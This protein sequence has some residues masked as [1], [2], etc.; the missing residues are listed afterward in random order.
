MSLPRAAIWTLLLLWALFMGLSLLALT[1]EPTGEGFLRGLNRVTGF[2]GWQ[3]GAA[4]VAFL[5][6]LGV[7]PLDRG[8]MLRR[9][10]RLP[11]WWAVM[12]LGLLL[13]W[14]AIGVIGSEIGRRSA[15]TDP[16]GPVTVPVD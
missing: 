15:P 1:A 2:L 11:G 10:G 3:M 12:L 13:A 7:R 4:V 14:I 8:E 16:P 6:W 5:L 9:L